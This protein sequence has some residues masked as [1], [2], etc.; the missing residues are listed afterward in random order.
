MDVD[1]AAL[2]LRRRALDDAARAA[3]AA[4]V[5][6]LVL[7]LIRGVSRLAAYTATGGELDPAPVVAAAC[8]SGVEVYLPRAVGD[9]LEFARY[10]TGE[11]LV[12]GRFGVDQPLPGVATCAPTRLDLVLVPVVAFDRRGTRVGTGGGY[13]DR[14]FAFRREGGAAPRPLL[15]GLAY[16][17]QEMTALARHPWDVPL[18]VVVTDREL[19]QP[20][21]R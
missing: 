8:R 19:I 14:T 21:T 12:R 16:E 9:E 3:S 2:R 18:D 4:A 1:R 11:P 15:V 13:Y 10:V 6:P 17:W 5:A 20:D 7:P